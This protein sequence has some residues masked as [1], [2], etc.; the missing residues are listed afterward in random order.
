MGESRGEG[1]EP[2]EFVTDYLI[3][4]MFFWMTTGCGWTESIY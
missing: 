3:I 1:K 4:N 2:K